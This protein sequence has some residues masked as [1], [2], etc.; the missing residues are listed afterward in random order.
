LLKKINQ[1]EFDAIKK[2]KSLMALPYL[3]G[4]LLNSLLGVKPS[5]ELKIKIEFT[6]KIH[7]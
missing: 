6:N 5:I 2:I 1:I 7:S 3:S 4:I